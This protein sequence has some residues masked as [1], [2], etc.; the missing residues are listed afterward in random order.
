MPV[1]IISAQ[2]DLKVYRWTK[3]TQEEIEL[4]PK[5]AEWAVFFTLKMFMGSNGVAYPAASTLA[6]ITGCSVPSVKRAIRSLISKGLLVRDG[7]DPKKNTARF[8][9][10]NS[11][12]GGSNL[13]GGISNLN[14]PPLSNLNTNKKEKQKEL[15]NK[16]NQTRINPIYLLPRID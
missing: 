16:N 14:T 1:T 8:R 15:I 7:F 2:K 4:L 3:I 13:V 5:N 9:L 12:E 10:G 11:A 6:E